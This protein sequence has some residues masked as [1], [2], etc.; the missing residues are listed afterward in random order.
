MRRGYRSSGR[1]A[2]D[3][4]PPPA[5]PGPGAERPGRRYALVVT[6]HRGDKYLPDTLSTAGEMLPFFPT[7]IVTRDDVGKVG[8][9]RGGRLARVIKWMPKTGRGLSASVAQAWSM[10][11]TEIDYVF[12]LEEDF[13]LTAPVDLD[14]MADVI[15]RDG[16]ANM[17][18]LRQ[19][20]TPEE[21]TAGGYQQS[22]AYEQ[23]AEYLFH[24]EGF[25]LN[26]CLI[27]ADVI[28]QGGGNEPQ[29]TEKH[30]DRGF[31][32]WGQ[33]DDPPRCLHVGAEGGMGT[34]GWAA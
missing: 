7:E 13:H 11:P 23:R 10:V 12:H 2:E 16:L 14:G 4:G 9:A 28:R 5:G 29:L 31:G 6:S 33:R 1:R 27:P 18:L 25:W 19:P 17:A 21:E 32:V 30:R 24:R 34:P 26:P 20:W 8:M 22:P 3:L 15:E